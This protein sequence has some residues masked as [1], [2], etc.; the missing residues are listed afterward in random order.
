MMILDAISRL[1]SLCVAYIQPWTHRSRF[2]YWR[3]YLNAIDAYS[4]GAEI[5]W[6]SKGAKEQKRLWTKNDIPVLLSRNGYGPGT[7]A[8]IICDASSGAHC[9]RS[10]EDIDK[11]ERDD[12]GI[13]DRTVQTKHTHTH[14]RTRTLG[15][16]NRWEKGSRWKTPSIHRVCIACA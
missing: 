6:K 10:R 11:R 4:F 8:C 7:Q 5:G 2:N 1:G 3:K 12:E 15:E 16:R 14:T 9:A 13:E